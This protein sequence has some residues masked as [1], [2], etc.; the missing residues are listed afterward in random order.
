MH[1]YETIEDYELTGYLVSREN[2]SDSDVTLSQRHRI[3]LTHILPA[4]LRIEYKPDKFR[5]TEDALPFLAEEGY[6][7]PFDET[8]DVELMVER[9]YDALVQVLFP[10]SSYLEEPWNSLPLVVEIEYKDDE[11]SEYLCSIG[12]YR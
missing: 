5:L 10:G 2:E 11:H 4:E 3:A 12:T 7:G 8:P 6:F 1:K 9:L